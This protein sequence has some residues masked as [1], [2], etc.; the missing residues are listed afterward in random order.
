MDRPVAVALVV[1]A[2]LAIRTDLP[3]AEALGTLVAIGVVLLLAARWQVAPIAIGV[4]LVI[5]VGL[6]AAV[7]IHSG[8][9]VLDVTS[10]AIQQVL[11][12]GN[13]Y[14][15]GYAASRPPGAPFPYGPLSLLWYAPV[16][17]NGWQLELVV[18]CIVLTLLAIRGR[19]LGLAIYAL[20]PTLVA[21]ASDGSNDTSV[22]LVLL[23]A[24][25]VAARRPVLGALLLA[26]AIALKPYA[27]AWAPAFVVW[28]GWATAATLVG[29]TLVLWSPVLLVW[30]V[31][32]FLKSLQMAGA[33]HASTY[34]SLGELFE[35]VRRSVASRDVFDT[36]RLV[37]GGATAVLTLRWA[38]GLDGVILAGTLVY[39]VTLFAGYWGTYAYF[40]AVAP[41]LCWRIDDWL[42]L[43]TRPLVNPQGGW[44]AAATGGS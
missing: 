25:V 13:P 44:Q 2:V 4:L 27:A 23:G 43:E 39:L 38:R 7:M 15:V 32:S 34:W 1:A 19:L 12:G 17:A 8:S 29:A 20:G 36:F 42:G 40:G 28:G 41:I 31:G 24:F 11:A 33:V 5:G 3:G 6:R 35:S 10:A 30:G 22:G 37:L 14:G 21:T 26:V 16:Q 18:S 9:D